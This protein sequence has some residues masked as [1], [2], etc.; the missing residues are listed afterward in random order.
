[1]PG[2]TH[3]YVDKAL[4]LPINTCPV[5]CRYCTRSYAIGGD[6]ETVEN[7]QLATDPKLWDRAF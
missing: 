7:A 2:L 5:Y 4:L 1:L 6:T 3:R